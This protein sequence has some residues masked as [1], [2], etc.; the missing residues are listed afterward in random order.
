MLQNG[1]RGGGVSE[2]LPLKKKGGGGVLD[3]LKGEKKS[4][5]VV[6]TPVFE[7]LCKPEGVGA[8]GFHP[9]EEVA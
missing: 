1:M 8:K 6:L 9:L 5:E 4:F 3:L 2:V 7:V